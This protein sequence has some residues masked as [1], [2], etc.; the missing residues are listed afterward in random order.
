M[1][2]RRCIP[3]SIGLT[4]CVLF[5]DSEI[6]SVWAWGLFRWE[7]SVI[8]LALLITTWNDPM[9]REPVCLT[10]VNVTQPRIRKLTGA[11]WRAGARPSDRFSRGNQAQKMHPD[12]FGLLLLKI[13]CPGLKQ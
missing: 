11:N 9:C 1:W 8:F 12:C 3:Y 10:M 4:T 5:L 2:I 13:P 7:N 6:I